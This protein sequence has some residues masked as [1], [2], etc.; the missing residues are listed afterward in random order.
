MRQKKTYGDSIEDRDS[1]VTFSVYGQDVVDVLGQEGVKL[2]YEW[3]SDDSKKQRLRDY[4]APLIPQ[5]EVRVGGVTSIDVTKPGIDK[6]YGMKK[7]MTMLELSKDDILF[8]GDRLYEG[9]NDYP[10][11]VMGIDCLE[12]SHW[13]ETAAAIEAILHVIR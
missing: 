9:G 11:K 10:I 4:I 12:I 7:L 6:A 13:Q 2:K 5:F 8:V 3:D 1:Q